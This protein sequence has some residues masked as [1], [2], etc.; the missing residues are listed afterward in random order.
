MDKIAGDGAEE[1][2]VVQQLID[3]QFH[4]PVL[5]DAWN[6]AAGDFE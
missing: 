4:E 3:Q 1:L 6:S 2:A 5:A